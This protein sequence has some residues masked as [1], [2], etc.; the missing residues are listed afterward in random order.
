M[1]S[2]RT[3]LRTTKPWF[4][5]AALTIA[6]TP[7]FAQE[8]APSVT[9][10]RP[11]VSTP[12]ALSAPGWLELEAGGLFAHAADPTHRT[13]LPYT[14]KLAFTP[15][16][17]VRLGGEAWVRQTDAAGTR[18]SGG[19]DTSVV[20]KRRIAIDDAR[21][22]GVEV[23]ANFATAKSTLGSGHESLGLTG[24]YSADLSNGLHT[25]LNVGATRATAADAGT[26]RVQWAGA[27]SLS[28]ALT[29]DFGW[30]AEVSGTR[31]RGIG[32]S[33]QWLAAATYNV[34]RSATLDIGLSRSLHSP[35][36]DGAWFAG[37][38]VLTGR[39]F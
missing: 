13:S 25:D 3:L 34:S 22:F 6:G 23:G 27:G 5:A 36:S 38:T 2:C 18:E 37:V 29:K 30:V 21:A 28:G 35:R 12:A 32:V 33:S 11:S 19:G 39:L 24:I 7:V 9:P 15:D 31:Q 10:Y 17:G 16:W 1:N 8:E 14:L 26:S 4:V 20:L